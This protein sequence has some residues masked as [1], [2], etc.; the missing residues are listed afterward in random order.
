M[1]TELSAL[2]PIAL[3]PPQS[4][5]PQVHSAAATVEG[6]RATAYNGAPAGLEHHHDGDKLDPTRVEPHLL[7][8]TCSALVTRKS[9]NHRT[10]TPFSCTLLR[11]QLPAREKSEPIIGTFIRACIFLI[12]GGLCWVTRAAENGER[13]NGCTK[14]Q[15]LASKEAPQAKHESL[16]ATEASFNARIVVGGRVFVRCFFLVMDLCRHVV[17]L[18]GVWG[19]VPGIA[20]RWEREAVGEPFIPPLFHD[21]A[22]DLLKRY[23]GIVWGLGRVAGLLRGGSGRGL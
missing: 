12:G 21:G 23:S 10:F 22:L 11:H 19:A 3:P 8:R 13:G 1:E 6:E 18:V 17:P 2:P 20:K 4:A 16:V 7:D 5:G 15:E 14:H 9:R